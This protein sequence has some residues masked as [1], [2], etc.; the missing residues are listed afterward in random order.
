MTFWVSRMSSLANRSDNNYYIIISRYSSA[1]TTE[2]GEAP[3]RNSRN[4]IREDDGRRIRAAHFYHDI[5]LFTHTR[6]HEVL[7][8]FVLAMINRGI[9]L[10]A[11]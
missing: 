1:P 5:R 6:R 2:L 7:P 8:S 9:V 11:D 4:A 10:V 3:R